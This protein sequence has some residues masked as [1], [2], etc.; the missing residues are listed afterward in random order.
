MVRAGVAAIAILLLAAIA[1]G[2]WYL[3]G[4]GP[5]SSISLLSE[6]FASEKLSTTGLVNSAAI[7][8]DGESVV[9]SVRNGLRQSLW[10]RQ[11]PSATNIEIIPPVDGG[12]YEIVFS[13][14]G[15]SLFF[16]RG[17]DARRGQ[18]DIFRL[19]VRGGIPQKLA[20]DTQG[21]LSISRDA[22]R[23]SFVRCDYTDD[24]YCSLWVANASDGGNE[25]KLVTSQRP[26]RIAD[27]EI[28][29]DGTKVA[30]ALGQSRN[31]ANEFRLMEVG[32]DG[33]AAGNNFRTVF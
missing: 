24:E 32:I 21:W 27:N 4:K 9:Y 18:T 20:A 3:L 13:P 31:Q 17:S 8:P 25:K 12:Y 16:S 14:D 33:G 26:I 29:P 11:L 15:N 19:P 22:D 6:P 2:S 28:S 1:A 7:S 23:I 5:E 10:I 30:F